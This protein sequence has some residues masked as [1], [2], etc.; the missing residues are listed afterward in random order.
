MKYNLDKGTV[1]FRWLVDPGDTGSKEYRE[2]G[3]NKTYSLGDSG[4]TTAKKL[5]NIINSKAGGS[6]YVYFEGDP[7]PQSSFGDTYKN[8]NKNQLLKFL[9]KNGEE[10]SEEKIKAYFE[11]HTDEA[12]SSGYSRVFTDRDKTFAGEVYIRGIGE[13]GEVYI[14]LA[15]LIANDD[16]DEIKGVTFTEKTKANNPNNFDMQSY[17]IDSKCYADAFFATMDELDDRKKVQEQIHSYDWKSSLSWNVSLGDLT[18]FVPPINIRFSNV[19]Q[20]ERMPVIRS[21]GS[22]SKT[23]EK[24]VRNLEMD[25]YFNE[26]KGINGY[27]YTETLPDGKTK[28]TYSMDGFRALESMFRFTPYLPITNN[29]INKTLGIDAVV[30]TNIAINSVPSFPKL[31]KVTLMMKEFCWQV[32][33]PDIVQLQ[34]Y[35]SKDSL[36]VAEQKH[37]ENAIKYWNRPKEEIEKDNKRK[38]DL[39]EQRAIEKA[40]GLETL[41]DYEEN[42]EIIESEYRNWFAMTFNWKLFRYYYQKPIRRGDYIRSVNWDFNSD[43]Y[44]SATCG[45]KTSYI[46]MKFEDPNIKFYVVNEKYLKRL[47]ELKFNIRTSDL[48]A[49]NFNDRQIEVM[50]NLADVAAKLNVYSSSEEVQKK[51]KDINKLLVD[52]IA[53]ARET[54][55]ALDWATTKSNAPKG[56]EQIFE[57]AG[58]RL[59]EAD[60]INE[61]PQN[62]DAEEQS[63]YYSFSHASMYDGALVKAGESNIPSD[64]QSDYEYGITFNEDAREKIDK[65]LNNIKTILQTT[66]DKE[67]FD[68]DKLDIVRSLNSSTGILMFGIT[69]RIKNQGLSD[70]ERESIKN[71]LSLIYNVKVGDNCFYKPTE[72]IFMEDDTMVIPLICRVESKGSANNFYNVVDNSSFEFGNDENSTTMKMLN[73]MSNLVEYYTKKNQNGMAANKEADDPIS[74][75][76]MKYDNYLGDGILVTAWSAQ[77]SN[78]MAPLRTLSG[79]CFAP[80]YLGGEDTYINITIYTTDEEKVKKLADLPKLVSKLAR[81]YH[82]VMPYVPL[83]IDSEFSRLLGVNEVT[84]EDAAIDTVP[85]QPGLYQI[86]MSFLST[87]RIT[88]EKES[89]YKGSFDNFRNTF[90]DDE[91]SKGAIMSAV[92]TI[93]DIISGMTH[94]NGDGTSDKEMGID[95]GIDIS[96]QY[97][98]IKDMLAKVDLYPDLELPKIKELE[99]IGYNFVRYK[100]EDNRTYV[101]PDFYFVYPTGLTSQ[102][103]RELVVYGLNNRSK[104]NNLSEI[105]LMDE[106]SNAK[107]VINPMIGMGYSVNANRSNQEFKDGFDKMKQEQKA[108]EE[109]AKEARKNSEENL[110]EKHDNSVDLVNRLNYMSDKEKWDICTEICCMFLESRFLKELQSYEAREKTNNIGN[111]DKNLGGSDKKNV[112]DSNNKVEDDN[113]K[114]Q[115]AVDKAR[116]ELENDAEAN[117]EDNIEDAMRQYK[118]KSDNEIKNKAVNELARN[119]IAGEKYTEGAYTNSKFSVVEKAADEYIKHLQENSP[120]DEDTSMVQFAEALNDHDYSKIDVFTT[121]SLA[122]LTS[123]WLSTDK[124]DAEISRAIDVFLSLDATKNI[125]D[126]LCIKHTDNKFVNLMKKIV[127]AAACTATASKE[128]RNNK[129]A[130]EW[131]PDFLYLGTVLEMGQGSNKKE[132]KIDKPGYLPK[133][134][135]ETNNDYGGGGGNFDNH[136]E[137][138]GYI[139]SNHR[140]LESKIQSIRDNGISFGIFKIKLLTKKKLI[141]LLSPIM[142]QEE[143]IPS[144]IEAENDEDVIGIHSEYLLLDPYYR[145]SGIKI[146]NIKNYKESCAASYYFSTIAFLR[147]LMYWLCILVKLK[148]YPAVVPDMIRA[149]NDVEKGIQETQNAYVKGSGTNLVNNKVDLRRYI[150]FYSNN[151]Y[152]IDAGKIFLSSIMALCDGDNN[153][154]GLVKRRDYGGLNATIRASCIPTKNID[155][156]YNFDMLCIRKMLFALMAQGVIDEYGKIGVNK[157]SPA[158]ANAREAVERLYLEAAEDPCKYIPHSFNDMVVNDARGRMLRAFPTFYMIF[159]D[160]GRQ[161]GVW[162]LHDNFYHINSIASIEIIKSRKIPADTCRIVMSNFYNSYSTEMIDEHNL[163]LQSSFSEAF[164]SVFSPSKYAY[165][166]EIKRINQDNTS[167]VSSG[168][169][170]PDSTTGASENF[171][172]SITESQRKLNLRL[173]TGTRMHIRMGYGNNANMLPIMFNGVIAEM[174]CESA[175]EIIAQG[176]G[177]ELMNPIFKEGYVEDQIVKSDNFFWNFADGATPLEIAVSL[178]SNYGGVMRKFVKQNIQLNLCDRNPFGIVHFGDPDF[179]MFISTGEPTQNLYESCTSPINGLNTDVKSDAYNMGLFGIK[180]EE[181]VSFTF[182]V[183]QKT[184]WDILHICKSTMPG[185]IIGIAPFGF[186]STCFMGLPHYY[187]C[188]DYYKDVD[189]VIKERR[190]PYQQWHIYTSESDVIDNKIAASSRDIKTVALGLYSVGSA[191]ASEQK[192]VGPLFA[193]W[194]IYKELQK[195]MIV[196]TQLLGRGVPVLGRLPLIGWLSN[197]IQQK[198]KDWFAD[199]KGLIYSDKKLAWKQTASALRE[200]IL[201]MYTGSLVLIGDPSVKPHDRFYLSDS[202]THMNGQALVKDVTHT[203]SIENGFTTVISPDCITCVNDNTEI[204]KNTTLD[205]IACIGTLN[206]DIVDENWKSTFLGRTGLKAG[207]TLAAVGSATAIKSM[208]TKGAAKAAETALRKKGL[209]AL[210][211]L[212]NINPWLK[213]ATTVYSLVVSPMIN[214]FLYDELKNNKVITIFPLKKYGHVYTAGFDGSRGCVYGSPTWGDRGTFGDMFDW[215]DEKFGFFNN[216][217]IGG[218]SLG[219]SIADLFLDQDVIELADKFRKTNVNIQNSGTSANIEN[220]YGSM[221]ARMN[222]DEYNYLQNSYKSNQLTPRVNY[223]NSAQVLNALQTYAMHDIGNYK[224]DPKFKDVKLI[225]QDARIMPYVDEQFFS[226]VHDNST[227]ND[228][229]REEIVTIKGKEYRIK[230]IE[231]KDDKG[232]DILDLPML[233]EDAINILYEIIRRAKNNMPNANASDINES[234]E[235]TKN[236]FIVLKSAL[237]VGDKSSMAATGFTFILQAT[238]SNSQRALKNALETLDAEFKSQF[239]KDLGLQTDIFFYEQNSK[240]EV[241]V[242][243]SMPI[244]RAYETNEKLEEEIKK[245]KSVISTKAIEDNNNTEKDKDS[246]KNK[247]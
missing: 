237:R 124:A 227:L 87:D 69:V 112:E 114:A 187:Y 162:K 91:S 102:L 49:I 105:N 178:F 15:K 119:S 113:K 189:N 185:F 134:E 103:Y 21:K 67:T 121:F 229:Y 68:I 39:K 169:E 82:A 156:K 73:N 10:P 65:I 5:L 147:I 150:N 53:Y 41:D 247:K 244:T 120:Y 89:P 238:N 108:K 212:A 20:N 132:I 45:A 25:L 137:E 118:N 199:D 78:R 130:L 181:A 200:S 28:V 174:S 92:T 63:K 157:S 70:V 183:F 190:K 52:S 35:G 222:G 128:Y 110:Q 74:L 239:A 219:F 164:D 216:I 224:A 51:I 85:N 100:F 213:V 165:E 7:I 203:L 14:N 9:Y 141:S 83:R 202:F 22:L 57:D 179:R 146:R 66:L 59:D 3:K 172:S 30:L 36:S 225:S 81:T 123:K 173:R 72:E 223:S 42:H 95:N 243:V 149:L 79:D 143:I 96:Q 208:L 142:K 230:A 46:P 231:G 131:K 38:E 207:G 88:R 23:D 122:N 194:D 221:L 27:A 153:I 24:T 58:D 40:K 159:I 75:L 196:D 158:V 236:D 145:N 12:K 37:N 125:L 4:K 11:E 182:D 177:I 101:D 126:A 191:G 61:D 56:Y 19:I 127:Y 43:A 186:R 206:S 154:L 246:D 111:Q 175:V 18:F 234:W 205:R 139:K 163:A 17:N 136:E 93:P 220:R 1:S 198:L 107:A 55:R 218:M 160:E 217:N 26:D 138:E 97:F 148:V 180:H 116:K 209:S 32:Y 155:A 152:S 86:G 80:Q 50:K 133:N 71:N 104:M 33:M 6:I 117:L 167:G 241:C 47:M 240:K 99:E 226:I 233:N 193:D 151:G 8:F 48:D 168:T 210:A 76:N 204:M 13:A 34:Q 211:N 140:S 31:L 176:D 135:K 192:T 232:N 29:Y 54:E 228:N 106:N 94:S 170:N 129:N 184:P 171:N 166:Q 215:V 98:K 2:D 188:Y 109:M 115:D 201:D 84:I 16:Q 245:A 195:T 161:Y 44:I 64:R 77:T 62:Q 197:G 214:E 144:E 90:K 242:T 60:Y 235:G